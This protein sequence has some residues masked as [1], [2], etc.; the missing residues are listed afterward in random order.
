M[1]THAQ[2]AKITKKTMVVRQC[3]KHRARVART[4]N[5]VNKAT[6]KALVDA[7]QL[8]DDAA[9]KVKET[10]V[11]LGRAIRQTRSDSIK[12]IADYEG[13]SDGHFFIRCRG[14]SKTLELE[15]RATFAERGNLTVEVGDELAVSGY[16]AE[17][18][19]I[20]TVD[21]IGEGNEGDERYRVSFLYDDTIENL[22]LK[23]ES[24]GR[25]LRLDPSLC[26]S[27]CHLCPAHLCHAP[28]DCRTFAFLQCAA[29]TVL[30]LS[31]LPV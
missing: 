17:T 8:K 21:D 7:E 9:N 25:G 6:E 24:Y 20:A 15:R 11:E 18:W 27:L 30:P 19:F 1:S 28:I 4:Q 2:A 5:D 3:G 13:E 31:L 29:L 26:L 14:E 12:P 16:D 22:K 10:V 23:A